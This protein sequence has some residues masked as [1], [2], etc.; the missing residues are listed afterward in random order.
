MS[1]KVAFL[2]LAAALVAFSPLATVQI[3]SAQQQNSEPAQNQGPG[4]T[5]SPA[6]CYNAPQSSNG[7]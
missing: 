7:C 5:N 1:K 6:G 2:M 4:N 3:A